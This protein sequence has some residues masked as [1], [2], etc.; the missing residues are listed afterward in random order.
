MTVRY[1]NRTTPTVRDS[2]ASTDPAGTSIE[3]EDSIPSW[4]QV[5]RLSVTEKRCGM[6]TAPVCPG[7]MFGHNN[8]ACGK[9]V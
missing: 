3:P 4:P 9:M 7:G 1:V 8:V 6:H 5:C 2:V